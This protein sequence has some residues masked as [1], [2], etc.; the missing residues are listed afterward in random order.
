MNVANS[1]INGKNALKGNWGLSIA[2]MVLYVVL[3]MSF[4]LFVTPLFSDIMEAWLDLVWATMFTPVI[5]AGLRWLHLGLVDGE[6]KRVG[7]IFDSFKLYG[8]LVAMNFLQGIIAALCAI[9]PTLIVVG[10]FASALENARTIGGAITI[11]TL[12][13]AVPIVVIV[14]VFL[15]YSQAVYLFKGHPQMGVREALKASKELMQGNK[16]DYFIL[17]LGYALWYLPAIVLLYVAWYQSAVSLMPVMWGG[18]PAAA[19][20][21]VLLFGLGSIYALGIS[22][23][24]VPQWNMAMAAFHR[25]LAPLAVEENDESSWTM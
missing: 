2:A 9:I 10:L 22:F 11:L 1:R 19:E 3:T 5:S 23:Y 24:V 13:F 25:L 14:V 8:Q 12:Y 20:T 16:V 15:R 21:A 17:N 7:D 18:N 4:V 6:T